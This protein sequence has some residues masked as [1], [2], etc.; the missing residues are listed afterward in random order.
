MLAI[1]VLHEASAMAIT[2]H[3]KRHLSPDINSK[4]KNNLLGQQMSSGSASKKKSNQS[5]T[6]RHLKDTKLALQEKAKYY[7]QQRLHL[8]S[9]NSAT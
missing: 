9:Q 3:K 2:R 1:N 7:E 6:L 5:P 8:S 4:Q